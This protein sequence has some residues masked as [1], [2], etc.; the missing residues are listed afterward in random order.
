[1]RRP[2]IHLGDRGHTIGGI[3][4]RAQLIQKGAQPD[5][6]VALRRHLPF[7]R[8]QPRLGGRQRCQRAAAREMLGGK[9]LR[10]V[11]QQQVAAPRPS[12]P[13]E[14]QQQQHRAQRHQAHCAQAE[15]V[16][17]L[18]RQHFYLRL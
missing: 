5:R 13:A 1:M 8:C 14:A 16:I 6:Q 2:T 11:A 3:H 12:A 15:Q 10:R 18:G 17:E 9:Q 7:D 4:D